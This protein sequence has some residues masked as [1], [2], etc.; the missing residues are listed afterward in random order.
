MAAWLIYFKERFPLPVYA[1]L[2]G[3]LS[4]SGALL[5][6]NGIEWLPTTIGF[7]GLMIFFAV[8]RLMD[9][10]KD[11]EK[12]RIAHPERPLPRG[13]ITV[14]QAS[15]AVSASVVLMLL[16]SA[17]AALLTSPVAGAFFLIVTAYLWL[18]FREFYCGVW[19]EARPLLYAVTHQLILLP[20][21]YFS[22]LLSFPGLLVSNEPFYFGLLLIGS[23]FAYEVCRKLDPG[24]HP[25]LR[26]YLHTHGRTGSFLIVTIAL[27]VAG[28]GGWK[29][30]LSAIVW[31]VEFA[32]LLG[33]TLI[34]LRPHAFKVVEGLASLCLVVHVWAIPMQALWSST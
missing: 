7:I 4:A 17:C 28:A 18:M 31:P 33:K 32:L 34:W 20:L 1:V 21:A 19:L 8:L 12:D 3:G 29:L 6:G 14:G 15:R 10:I 2:V 26:T 5:A 22:A 13:L 25:I 24:A 16:W 30:G 23:F 11:Y 9:E 27:L